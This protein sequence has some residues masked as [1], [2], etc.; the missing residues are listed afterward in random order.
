[1]S[2]VKAGNIKKGM[3]IAHNGRPH[4]VTWTHFGSMGR[5]SAFMRTKLKDLKSGS[6]VDYTFKS[7]DI[8]EELDIEL[9][10]LQFL[11]RTEDEV[12]LM[13]PRDFE[14]MSVEVSLLD[15]KE[16]FLAPEMKVY[17]Q[18]FEEKPIGI[19]LPPKVEMMVEQ[20]EDA[21][22]G[23]RQTAGKKAVTMESGLIV[24]APLFIKKGDRLIIDVETGQ[25][26][27]RKN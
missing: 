13:D 4:V 21:V 18:L 25:Y 27:S 16:E 26:I 1:M 2:K 19:S 10:E 15:G 5:G 24:Q 20:A 14:Q 3:H 12:V 7:H 9:K 8:A 6:T 11:Y 23:D 17:V 22:S